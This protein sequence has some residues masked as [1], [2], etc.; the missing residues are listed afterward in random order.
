MRIARVLPTAF[1]FG[2]LAL[3]G[4]AA[5]TARADGETEPKPCNAKKFKIKKVEKACKD[6]GQPAVK[7]MM[8]AAVKKAKAAGEDINC[9]SCHNSLKEFDLK[10]GSE[11]IKKWL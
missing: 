11:K 2:T 8:K 5:G 1:L 9:K 10:S 6:G 3:A 7:K 4:F